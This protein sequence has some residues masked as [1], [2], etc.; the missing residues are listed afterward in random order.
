MN[1][2]ILIMTM[3][4][5]LSMVM[6]ANACSLKKAGLA[7]RLFRY[8]IGCLSIAGG[9]FFATLFCAYAKPESVSMIVFPFITAL[10][11]A[12][13]VVMAHWMDVIDAQQPVAEAGQATASR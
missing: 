3:L 11:G 9:W 2:M 8:V 13:G 10:P 6:S 1:S 12:L 5:V 7:M 4:F